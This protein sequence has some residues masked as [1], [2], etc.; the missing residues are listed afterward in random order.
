MDSVTAKQPQQKARQ[1]RNDDGNSNDGDDDC[2]GDKDN[3][4]G[5]GWR[6]GD[7]Q[8]DGGTTAT[9]MGGMTAY[10]W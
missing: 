2:D 7:R 5:N 10:N 8:R 9:A 4:N 3:G 6:N 1:R